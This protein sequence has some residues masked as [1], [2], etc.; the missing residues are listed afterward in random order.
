MAEGGVG[1]KTV[2]GNLEGRGRREVMGGREG[3]EGKGAVHPR[4][5]EK[6]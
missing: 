2:R 6:Y 1:I 4:K 5:N 3:S